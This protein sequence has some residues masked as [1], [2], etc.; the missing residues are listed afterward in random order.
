MIAD[1]YPERARAAC[2]A[3]GWPE[4][5][6]AATNFTDDAGAIMTSCAVDLVVEATGNPVTGIRH[7]RQAIQNGLHIV[8]V[9]VEADVLAGAALAAEARRQGWST[10]WPMA[11]NLP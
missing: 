11:I 6:I 3:V 1:L 7:A 8:M 5:L 9:N 4:S 10:P 2:E